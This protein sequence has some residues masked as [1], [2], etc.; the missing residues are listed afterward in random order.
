MMSRFGERSPATLY[1]PER[2]EHL[3]RVRGRQLTDTRGTL[4]VPQRSLAQHIEQQVEVQKVEQQLD[5]EFKAITDYYHIIEAAYEQIA[6]EVAEEEAA[7]Q[8]EAVIPEVVTKQPTSGKEILALLL[9]AHNEELIIEETIKSAVAAGQ[10]IEHIYVVNDNSSDKTRQ[11][12]TRL[13]GKANVLNVKRSG[14]ALAVKKATVKFNIVERYEWLH[15]ADADSIFSQNYFRVY[16]KKLDS[17]K[18][19]VALGF[20]QSLRGN[21]ISS[22]R[23][24]T[25][26]K[27]Q[28][29]DRRIQSALGM[30]SVF[31]GAVTCLRTDI[32]EKLSF[33]GPS[34][35][36]DFDITLQVHR[37]KLGNILY[38]PQAVN[39]TQDPQSLRDFCN[40]NLRWMRG[41]FQGVKKYG[42]GLHG[43]RVDMYLGLQMFLTLF[44]LVQLFVISPLLVFSNDNGWLIVLYMLAIDFIINFSIA[45]SASFLAK[46]WNLVGVMPYFYFLRSIEIGITVIAF[47]EVF[48]LHKFN[49][50]KAIGWSTAGRRYKVSASA[51]VDVAH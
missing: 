37:K 24:L 46:R 12:A 17:E 35:T 45:F 43:Q 25:Y 20:V 8:T 40:Q 31:P 48:A 15:V 49:D 29:F 50:D 21:W 3:E 28:Q 22:Y 30:I 4:Q 42:I 47:F 33:E 41:F 2:Q 51:M 11:I 10:A 32:I 44:F 6:K 34:L 5:T 16:R 19:A 39:Y 38:I 7:T 13:L 36:E 18:Y 23:A 9:P 14:K 1:V 27:S 26:T